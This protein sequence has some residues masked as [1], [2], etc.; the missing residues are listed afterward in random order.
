MLSQITNAFHRWGIAVLGAGGW[1]KA[2]ALEGRCRHVA[3]IE[4][5]CSSWGSSL[6]VKG[7]WEGEW[8]ARQATEVRVDEEYVL[9]VNLVGWVGKERGAPSACYNGGRTPPCHIS[10]ANRPV[11]L[12]PSAIT[13]HIPPSCPPLHPLS[14]HSSATAAPSC[15]TA[16]AAALL[17][18]SHTLLLLTSPIPCALPPSLL[19]RPP[20]SL[21]LLLPPAC[22]VI[23][24][25]LCLA[26][27]LRGPLGD[28]T[29]AP[30]VHSNSLPSR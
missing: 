2:A 18:Y 21:A 1:N 8:L 12:P 25:R 26:V 7:Y 19:L 28:S 17:T 20:S 13:A 29:L 14:A 11:S 27:I 3:V 6:W 15:S 24:V 22:A 16:P 23:L 30:D 10:N 5:V 9:C 4:L